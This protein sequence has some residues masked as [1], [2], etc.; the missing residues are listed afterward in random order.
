MGEDADPFLVETP[1][2]SLRSL[3]RVWVKR[4]AVIDGAPLGTPDKGYSGRFSGQN[5][6]RTG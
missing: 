2:E 1:W 4:N 5:V 3:W 6:S